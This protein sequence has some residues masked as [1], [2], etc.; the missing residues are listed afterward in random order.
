M[1]DSGSDKTA[2]GS[3]PPAPPGMPRW[4]KVFGLVLIG[5]LMLAGGLMLFGGGD[6]GPG[7]HTGQGGAGQAIEQPASDGDSSGHAP[8]EGGHAPPEA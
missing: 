6:H 5:V 3:D 2:A 7:R 8:P 4:V 1:A